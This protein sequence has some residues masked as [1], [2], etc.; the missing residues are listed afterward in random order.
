MYCLLALQEK[1]YKAKENIN[2][3]TENINASSLKN[4]KKQNKTMT[5]KPHSPIMQAE[6]L[7]IHA[8]LFPVHI[9]DYDSDL[10]GKSSEILDWVLIIR[11]QI[12]PSGIVCFPCDPCS[13][14]FHI[15]L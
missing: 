13:S 10:Q 1:Y 14:S 11:R 9:K 8:Y 3:A 7:A 15:E 5:T 6:D 12:A 4:T 2:S